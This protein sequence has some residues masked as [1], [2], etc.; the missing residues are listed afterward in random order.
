MSD[1]RRPGL[2]SAD[3]WGGQIQDMVR[4]LLVI[5][6]AFLGPIA[7]L[8]S[9]GFA[10]YTLKFLV[11]PNIQRDEFLS[12]NTLGLVYLVGF[13]PAL[14]VGGVSSFTLEKNGRFALKRALFTSAIVGIVMA[15]PL[16]LLGHDS[17]PGLSERLKFVPMII[18]VN[19]C[20]TLL[21]W[22]LWELL[23]RCARMA[24]KERKA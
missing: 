16:L 18:W 13:L 12:F 24:W 10:F 8:L 7:G 22:A 14:V 3:G 11:S 4:F 19:I 15:S 1:Q 23:R 17:P 21:V 5:L 2:M 6:F 20:A 9:F